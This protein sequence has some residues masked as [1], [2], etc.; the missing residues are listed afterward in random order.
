M[1]EPQRPP[2]TTK[3]D[4]LLTW[5]EQVF[6]DAGLSPTADQIT[7]IAKTIA[8]LFLT[9][10]LV[11]LSE[12][13]GAADFAN[14][15]GINLFAGWLG[16]MEVGPPNILDRIDEACDMLTVMLADAELDT[17]EDDPRRIGVETRI[18][19][20]I[21]EIF[22]EELS[23]SHDEFVRGVREEFG[24]TAPDGAGRP[25]VAT[26]SAAAGGGCLLT[27]IG[28]AATLALIIVVA[29]TLG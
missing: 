21:N 4:A 15:R 5:S 20:E 2:S 7:E 23:T 11:P 27:A 28:I 13:R 26:S 6:A 22:G 16:E 19:R 8:G 1:D 10:R 18:A 3:R 14:A 12:A 24:S 29:V 25:G 9:E 17:H